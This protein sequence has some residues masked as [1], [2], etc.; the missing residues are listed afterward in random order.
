[1]LRR[2]LRGFERDL[3]AALSDIRVQVRVEPD[4]RGFNRALLRGLRE[5]F[6]AIR[7]PVEPDLRGF[8]T[9]LLRGLRGLEVSVRV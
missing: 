1:A 5:R 4:L 8:E 3:R 9:A 7:V 2:G 6:D